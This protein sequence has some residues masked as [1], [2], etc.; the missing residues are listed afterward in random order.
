MPGFAEYWRG[1]TM[2]GRRKRK[3]DAEMLANT[4]FRFPRAPAL[5][6]GPRGR[7]VV[8]ILAS[9][10]GLAALFAATG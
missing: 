9:L 5:R 6:P 10:A 8:L 7:P 3:V 1:T 2:I 4:V